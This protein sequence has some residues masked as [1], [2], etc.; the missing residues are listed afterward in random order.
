APPIQRC[1]S[2]QKVS[3]DV[4]SSHFSSRKHEN[5]VLQWRL[6]GIDTLGKYHQ[7]IVQG[8]APIRFPHRAVAH[9][10]TIDVE[11]P[12][13]TM[14]CT[15]DI[16]AFASENGEVVAQNFVQFLVTNGYPPPRE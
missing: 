9:A 4:S 3:I 6:S 10:H 5:V 7:N 16:E 2:G 1:A 11:M 14:I 13:Q 8:T 12:R 15:L